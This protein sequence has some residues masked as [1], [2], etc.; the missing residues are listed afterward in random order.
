MY[1]DVYIHVYV[2]TCVYIY[3]IVCIHVIIYRIYIYIY[4]LYINIYIYI[5]IQHS[6]FIDEALHTQ[7]L[8]EGNIAHTLIRCTSIRLGLVPRSSE[9]KD[10]ASSCCC[11][12]DSDR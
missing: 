7:R 8:Q 4:K 9:K 5:I 10:P 12:P 3:I 1:L 2:C 6:E 11:I